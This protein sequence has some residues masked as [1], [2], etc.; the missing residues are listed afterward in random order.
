M[1]ADVSLPLLPEHWAAVRN[2]LRRLSIGFW[3]TALGL[4]PIGIA[5]SMLGHRHLA[6]SGPTPAVRRIERQRFL[7]AAA[8]LAVFPVVLFGRPAVGSGTTVAVI[9]VVAAVGLAGCTLV[10]L[11]L[12]W[13]CGCALVAW[14]GSE[15]LG[16]EWRRVPRTTV[17]ALLAQ[18]GL[19]VA[20]FANGGGEVSAVAFLA[21]VLLVPLANVL[22]LLPLW[23]TSW[24]TYALF[25]KPL[26]PAYAAITPPP[27]MPPP[28]APALP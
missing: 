4:G 17:L 27:P 24:R 26:V 2:G 22:A 5:V 21:F 11:V 10:D 15:T 7:L 28:P 12:W 25:R 9:V 8:T 13:R 23:F 20:M 3:L 14:A 16:R 6:G 19:I 18:A 1:E